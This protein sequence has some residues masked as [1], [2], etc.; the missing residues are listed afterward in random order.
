MSEAPYSPAE[1]PAD[2]DGPNQSPPQRYSASASVP[3]PPPSNQPPQ[4][5][6]GAPSYGQ[7]GYGP[8]GSYGAGGQIGQP[9][10][11]GQSPPTG[12]ARVAAS[13]SVPVP[14]AAPAPSSPPPPAA[15]PPAPAAPPLP[16]GTYGSPSPYAP[17]GY[18]QAQGQGQGQ[19]GQPP[20]GGGEPAG[21]APMGQGAYQPSYGQPPPR[22]PSVPTGG[23]P[24]V[25]SAPAE[26]RK[27]RK[28]LIITLI[29]VAVVLVVAVG[30]YVG[31]SLTT[32][33]SEFVEGACVKQSGTDAVVVD[34]S[35]AG[36]FQITTIADNE[37]GCTDPNQ[38]TVVLTGPM[39]NRRFACL[40]PAG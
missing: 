6:G 24:Y 8:A 4:P 7:P 33:G 34:C 31:W 12:T 2:D 32:R 19:Y 39:G 38:P 17:P 30:G 16:P 28:G 25:E 3:V 22:D 13:A 27:S 20:F 26:E 14:P 10:A 35:E 15:P 36:A 11:P 29:V 5:Y 1:P 18:G 21:A 23:W 40:A 9:P 37:A